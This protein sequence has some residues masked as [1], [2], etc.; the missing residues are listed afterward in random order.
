M[1]ITKDKSDDSSNLREQAEK[2]AKQQIVEF[3]KQ[4]GQN[5]ADLI[6]ELRVH[7]IELEMQNEEL[8]RTQKDLE[9]S[10]KRFSD[11]YDFAPVGYFTLNKDGLIVEANL[12]CAAFLGEERG[13]L[14][15]S[16]LS[17]FIAPDS[18][19]E[20]YLHCKQVVESGARQSCEV[21]LRRKDGTE[22]FAQLVSVAVAEQ[23]GEYDQFRMTMT[24]ITER[25]K[26]EKSL[27]ASEL[28]YHRLFEAAC[29][30]ILILDEDF[31]RI[32]DVNPFIENM[33][34][35][36][37][38]ELLDKHLWEIGFFKDVAASKEAFLE[39]QDKGYIRYGNLPLKTKDGRQIAV[40]F[41][42]NV[43]MV[44]HKKVIQCNIR[45]ITERAMVEEALH[46]SETRFRELFNNM[47]SG[48]A[49]YEAIEEGKDFVFRDFNSAS[50]KIEKVSKENVIGKRVTTVFPDVKEMGLL[51]VFHRVWKT[52]KTEQH[53][54]SIY[55][56]NRIS[57]WRENYVYKL[58]SGELV[59]VYDD[60]TER[61][62][63]EE[64]LQQA[65]VYNRS[66]IEASP[67]PLVAIGPDGK[68]TD[69]NT[70]TEAM[71]GYTRT[72]IIGTDFSH[73]FTEPKNAQAGYLQ[74]FQEGVVH[75][76]PL[77]IRHRDGH[78]TPVLYNASVYRN[79]AGEVVGVFAAARDITKR[80]QVEEKLQ[81]ERNLLRTLIDHI[82]D[83][84]YVKDKDSRFVLCN[85]AI[86]EIDGIKDEKDIIGKS[87]FDLYDHVT[88]Q[89]LFDSEQE[90]MRTNMQIFNLECQRIDKTGKLQSAL[91]TKV[92]LRDSHGNVTGIVGINRDITERKKAEQKILEHQKQLKRVAT[93]LALTEERERRRIA[94]EL[95]DH[96]S[97]SLALAKIKLD[98]LRSA[99]SSQPVAGVI[100]DISSSIEKAI[101]DTR[102]LTFDLSNPIL[103]ELGFEAAVSEWLNENVRDKHKINI[104]FQD[105]GRDKPLDDDMRALLFRN[106]RELLINAIKYANADKVKVSIRRI[107]GS[108][109][110]VIEDNGVGF[111]PVEVRTLASKRAEFGLFSIRE[112]MEELGGRFEIESKPGT[113][114]K[115]IMTVPLKNQ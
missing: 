43:Y 101:Q 57:G 73:Y 42:S 8:R 40:E 41:V 47:S 108:I 114:C 59:T 109:E 112:S 69:V 92:P 37:R 33:L 7:Q 30:G 63:A 9:E 100:E 106:V 87:D 54:T 20:F 88:A 46:T 3:R 64:E 98:S 107:D 86:L 110:I 99:L 38:N 95:H 5:P 18:Q 60:V 81:N 82:P 96:V 16:K 31:G 84:V 36:S 2:R 51:D 26:A 104:E 79:K 50:E 66:L 113:G 44:D 93:Q 55:K 6:H 115:A 75:D 15:K 24:D 97:Q 65:S 67:D 53:S 58:P 49:V 34:G 68:I 61:K 35:Y 56:D 105:D 10:R 102:T 111:D 52:G 71:T 76:Y 13:N 90:I 28:R 77:E 94:G 29:D 21:K 22:F 17:H 23:K 78:L 14:L 11:L 25:K 72:E 48:V 91:Q 70:A 45:D 83:K 4:R 74:V 89:E 39:L 19:D 32:V 27:L 12:T 103:Y 85:K 80:K 1:R 62:L